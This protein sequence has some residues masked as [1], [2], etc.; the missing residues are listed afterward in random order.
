MNQNT[1]LIWQLKRALL[2]FAENLSDGLTRPKMKFLSQ[3]LYGLL[4]SQSVMLTQIGRALQEAI[5][6]KKTEDRLSRNLKA[7][8]QDIE[9]VRQNYLESVKPLIDNE[10]IFC[11]DPGD[12]TKRYS[13]HQEG[14]EWIYDASDHKT[15]LG[16]HLYEVTALT[17]GKKLPIPV[18]TQVVSPNDPMSDDQTEAV[19][20]AIR[21]TQRAFG[22]VGIQ[23]MDRGMDTE[24]I[25]EHCIDTKQSFIIRGKVNRRLLVDDDILETIHIAGKM[26][27]K[28]RIDY[29]DKH[30]KKHRCRVSFQTVRL[31]SRPDEP[32]SLVMVYGYDKEPM[33]LLTNLA[34]QGKT[35]CLRVVKTYLCR[36]RVEEYYRFKKN[37]FDLENIR[38]LSMDS[39]SSLVFLQSVLSGWIAMFA[40]RQGE[41]LLLTEVLERAM[42]VYEIPQFS[43]YAVADGIYGILKGAVKGIRFALLHP[44]ISQQLS[45]FKPSAFILS[46]S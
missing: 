26:K 44:P 18:Y 37:Q 27:G 7:F 31:P 43:L 22:A 3:M 24:A 45:L 12:I 33:L 10:T 36:W 38:V 20:D 34:I 9:C 28:F 25:Y 29:T 15:A 21:T 19:L 35:T 41:S 46:A 13:R 14:L 39:I 23:T 40:N 8:R 42:R 30:G 16:W 17:H 2:N 6:L 4:A 1:T 32:L 11:L 5:S